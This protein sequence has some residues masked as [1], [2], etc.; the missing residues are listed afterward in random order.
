MMTST[1]ARCHPR[2]DRAGGRCVQCGSSH[3]VHCDHVIPYSWGGAD[4][5]ENLQILCQTCNLR[6][7][8]RH[9]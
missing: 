8:N 9:L 6:K 4:T 5:V 1:E 3:K 2:R 7:G